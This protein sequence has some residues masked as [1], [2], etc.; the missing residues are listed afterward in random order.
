MSSVTITSSRTRNLS[1]SFLDPG[2]DLN[3]DA[4]GFMGNVVAPLRSSGGEVASLRHAGFG[5]I[6]AW[7]EGPGDQYD[8]EQDDLALNVGGGVM[9]S[10]N[11]RVGLRADLRYFRAFV[12]ED[13]RGRRVLQGLWLPARD[14]R[15][16]VAGSATNLCRGKRPAHAQWTGS[17]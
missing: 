8:V 11:G 14:G 1:T 13:K 9:Y 6:H 5:V 10:L 4:W 17:R 2:T 16:H 12:D 15:G 3:T 7:V